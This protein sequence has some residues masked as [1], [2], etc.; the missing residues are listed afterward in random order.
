[1]FFRGAV[2]QKDFQRMEAALAL[3]S[4]EL[5]L[6][7]DDIGSRERLALSI[8]A[9][10]KTGQSDIEKLK[11]YA[12]AQFKRARGAHSSSAAIRD[13]VAPRRAESRRV[14]RS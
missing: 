4:E 2:D 11:V 10:H 6:A 14:E 13:P 3:A 8:L 12:V 7:D 1:M 9:L 5:N